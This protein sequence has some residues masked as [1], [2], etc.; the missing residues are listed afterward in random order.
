MLDSDNRSELNSVFENDNHDRMQ[1]RD[2]SD[3]IWPLLSELS[4][5]CTMA[6]RR[7]NAACAANRAVTGPWTTQYGPCMAGKRKIIK[8]QTTASTASSHPM[9]PEIIELP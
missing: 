1:D 8:T 9:R 7:R 3:E 5:A 2:K 4:A 6:I